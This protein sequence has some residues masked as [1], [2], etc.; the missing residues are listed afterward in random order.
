M[1]IKYAHILVSSILL[2]SC[3]NILFNSH[4][5]ET[6]SISILVTITLMIITVSSTKLYLD[7]VYYLFIIIFALLLGLV[8]YKFSHLPIREY[9]I[10]T[11]VLL[12]VALICILPPRNNR[13]YKY[14]NVIILS[15]FFV[16][17]II[18]SHRRPYIFVENNFEIVLPILV[19][20]PSVLNQRK[21]IND[22]LCIF[23]VLA[24]TL[25]SKSLVGIGC[26][27]SVFFIRYLQLKFLSIL[28]VIFISGVSLVAATLIFLQRGVDINS[29]DRILF[30]EAA[31]LHLKSAT[32]IQL[33]F[34]NLYNGP[35]NEV[36]CQ[37]LQ[38][39]SNMI[40]E[41]G[42][43]YSRILHAFNLRILVDYGICGALLLFIFLIFGITRSLNNV[44]FGLAVFVVGFVNG[45]SVSGFNN[46]FYL[47]GFCYLYYT[48]RHSKEG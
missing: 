10:A 6:T 29:I 46:T 1:T 21:N 22:Y 4:S 48:V 16:A 45:M 15:I 13:E 31:I 38:S 23:L 12:I 20:L 43:C 14:L 7:G 25:L 40:L 28:S 41:D 24:I 32:Q 8:H 3:L 27:G 36:S 42:S 26:L 33:L 9:L 35:L 39:Y 17:Y 2:L 44:R 47:I 37:L 34:G 18:D 19:A 11:K 30:Y 5:I